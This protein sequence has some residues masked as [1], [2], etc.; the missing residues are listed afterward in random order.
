MIN[1]AD[2]GRLIIILLRRNEQISIHGTDIKPS[3]KPT[4]LTTPT[5]PIEETASEI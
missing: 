2:L 4:T 1:G 5:S 3:P